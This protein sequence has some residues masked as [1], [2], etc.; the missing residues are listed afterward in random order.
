LGIGTLLALRLKM[1]SRVEKLHWVR[2]L[3]I[4]P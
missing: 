3:V 4:I 2:N 1:A